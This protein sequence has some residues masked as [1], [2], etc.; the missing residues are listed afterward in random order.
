MRE[1]NYSFYDFGGEQLAKINPIQRA[2]LEKSREEGLKK[3]L[4]D[5]TLKIGIDESMVIDRASIRHVVFLIGPKEDGS[6]PHKDTFLTLQENIAL[7]QKLTMRT[8]NARKDPAYSTKL[9][10]QYHLYRRI[11]VH[12][13]LTK[14]SRSPNPAQDDD[15]KELLKSISPDLYRI[16]LNT[17]GKMRYVNV[18]SDNLKEPQLVGVAEF[19][20][21]ILR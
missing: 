12:C 19:G 14:Y 15:V 4:Q 16:V 9:K 7:I 1:K 17:K 2:K 5:T 6:Y 8:A 20:D 11:K 13:L 21:V 10:R 3:L 18:R